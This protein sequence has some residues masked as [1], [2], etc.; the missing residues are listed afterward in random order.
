MNGDAFEMLFVL[1]LNIGIQ[2][3]LTIVYFKKSIFFLF[4]K[5]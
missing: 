3:S 4:G 2:L 5:F 1:Y